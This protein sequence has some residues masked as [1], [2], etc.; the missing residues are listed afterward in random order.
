MTTNDPERTDQDLLQS[1]REQTQVLVHDTPGPLRKVSVASGDSRVTVEWAGSDEPAQRTGPA[2]PT[3]DV[4]DEPEPSPDRVAVTAPLVG[5]F[6]RRPEPGAEPFVEEG[7]AVE[8]GQTVAIVEAMKL[9][10]PVKA[11]S[12]GTVATIHADDAQM[13]E[14][15]QTLMELD[16]PTADPPAAEPP[17][18]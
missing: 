5:T 14:F 3:E 15:D 17:P 18:S 9:M 7:S 8:V 1:L 16:P 2:P 10:N 6:Y 13:V 11:P 4:Q 12:S